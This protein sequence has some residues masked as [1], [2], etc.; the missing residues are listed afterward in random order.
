MRDLQPAKSYHDHQR[1]SV[2]WLASWYP[3]ASEPFSGDFIKRQ[4][5]A[6]SIYQ[7]LRIIYIGKYSPEP[8]YLKTEKSTSENSPQSLQEFIL[9]YPSEGKSSVISRCRSFYTYFR[10]HL[11]IIKQLRKINE[12]PDLVHVQ[13]AMKAG[14]IALYLKWKYKIPYILTEHWS[15]YYTQAKDSLSKKPLL[16]RN[17]T[18]L[19]LKKAERFL[20]VSDAL[21]N[22]INRHWVQIP[23]LKIPN[24]VNTSLFFP[25]GD[26]SGN[27]FRF[28]H[29]SSLLYPKNPEGIIRSF[30]S[31]LNQGFQADLVL[32]G[33]LNHFLTEILSI[34]GL[35]PDKIHCTGEITYEQVGIELRK[36]SALV[37]FSYYETLSCVILEA[38]CTGV[39]VI[40]T[41]VGGVPEVIQED[42][43][44]LIESGDEKELLEAMKKMMLNHSSYDKDKISR[45]AT[46]EFSY[47]T[48]G[49][50]IVEVYNS[51][52]DRK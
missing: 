42:N 1:K 12:L 10:K 4:A 21:G 26:P 47:E 27:V 29:I 20:P 35:S 52:L 31:L 38:L 45:R 24:T 15:G 8:R 22:Q 46:A 17:L 3:N 11:K 34:S 39:P 28:I 43:G 19:I 51:V 14:L 6:V 41:R 33:P 7:P 16:T 5:E 50:E 23:Y 32:V 9:Y 30:I 36:S 40:A 25:A 37:M 18:K 48:V 49:K 13:V 44:I 2:L